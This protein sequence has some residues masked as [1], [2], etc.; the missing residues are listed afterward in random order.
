M[1]SIR[2][3]LGELLSPSMIV[4][5]LALGIATSGTAYAITVSGADI[6]NGTVTT[7]DIKDDNLKSAD[8]KNGTLKPGD[9]ALPARGARAVA[10][11]YGDSGAGTCTIIAEYSR[12][13]TACERTSAGHYQ[14]TLAPSV[15]LTKSYP[16]C[17]FGNNGG[18]SDGA[19]AVKS[20]AV[21]R[22]DESHVRVINYLVDFDAADPVARLDPAETLPVIVTIP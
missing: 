3:R 10:A 13:F 8:I 2:K 14:L 11:V 9:L 7:K 18:T 20:C 4:A 21:T 1:S 16:T 19:Q 5:L 15:S 17:S 12:G 22:S 6:R